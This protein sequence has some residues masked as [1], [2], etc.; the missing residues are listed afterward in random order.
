M[1][2]FSGLTGT[3]FYSPMLKVWFAFFDKRRHALF[4]I[5]C[6]KASMKLATLEEYTFVQ[7]RLERSIH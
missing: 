2:G 1:Q 5:F 3:L 4:L 6:G 7:R